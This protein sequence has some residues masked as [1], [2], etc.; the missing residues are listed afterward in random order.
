MTI[1]LNP[2]TAAELREG[3]QVS[4]AVELPFLAPVFYALNGDQK[5]RQLGGAQYFG[6]FAADAAKLLDAWADQGAFPGLVRLDRPVKNK[7][8]DEF[9]TRALIVAPIGTRSSWFSEGQ[10]GNLTRSAD[11]FP[12]ARMH[13]QALVMVAH[14][15]DD[16]TFEP[17]N[18]AVLSGK[19][20]QAAADPV[21]IP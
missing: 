10:D 7:T 19:G 18:A 17:W 20:H 11:Y 14:K 15:K 2:D 4:N 21:G 16:G 5:L 3:M 12:G 13:V 6:G 8:I 9:I 1:V